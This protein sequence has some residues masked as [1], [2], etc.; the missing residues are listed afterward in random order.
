[1]LA[2]SGSAGNSVTNVNRTAEFVPVDDA[3]ERFGRASSWIFVA[4]LIL[5]GA[6]YIFAGL[7]NEHT[8]PRGGESCL[9]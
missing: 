1:M 7:S 8:L 6:T 4:V 9:V 5:S 3:L 2:A